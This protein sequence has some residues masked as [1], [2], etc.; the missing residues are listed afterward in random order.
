VK[1]S[2]NRRWKDVPKDELDNAG[3]GKPYD[4]KTAREAFLNRRQARRNRAL[5]KK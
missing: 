1:K 4:K 5:K 2:P 3:Q